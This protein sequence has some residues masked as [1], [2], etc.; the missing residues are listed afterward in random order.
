[1]RANCSRRLMSSSFTTFL[2]MSAG[3]RSPG[4]LKSSKSPART[5][6]RAQSCPAAKRRARPIP[7]HLQIP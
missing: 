2:G 1:M 4:H 5:R 7:T 6:S 3:L